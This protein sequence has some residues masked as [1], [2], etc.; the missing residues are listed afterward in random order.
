MTTAGGHETAG[1]P[2]S[3]KTGWWQEEDCTLTSPSGAPLSEA[4]DL[5][6]RHPEA[7]AID[8]LMIDCHGIGRGKIIRRHELEGLF[9][10]SRGMPASMFVRDLAGLH[11]SMA[12]AQRRNLFADQ[13]DGSLSPLTLHAI[14]GI[15]AIIGETMLILAPFL[16]S[17]RRFASTIY[18]LAN[19]TGGIDNR[20][21][22]LRVPSDSPQS[23]HF[24]HRVAGVDANPYLP[25]AVT[26]GA[27]LDGIAAQADPG[28]ANWGDAT[29]AA[30]RGPLPRNWLKAIDAFKS[31]DFARRL[32][33]V[34]LHQGFTAIKRRT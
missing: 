24:E 29:K 1:L 28:L 11:L 13:P 34:L 30:S 32:L 3:R 22:A 20:T 23:R 33:G 19:D 14:G 26:L 18:F 4:T 21:V 2:R 7:E 25:S 10:S 15:R 31:S 6:A 16:N 27:A 12:D 9:T 5:L 17:W 8:V